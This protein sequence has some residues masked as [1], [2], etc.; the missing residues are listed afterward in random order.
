M[1]K[2]EYNDLIDIIGGINITGV[3]I[4]AFTSTFRFIY[5]TGRNFGSA[6][7]RISSNNLCPI[8]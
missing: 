4:N 3:L 6:L 8:R 2:I 7:R 5:E 1:E